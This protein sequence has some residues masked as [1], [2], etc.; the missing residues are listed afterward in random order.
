MSFSDALNGNNP[1]ENGILLNFS[2]KSS[3]D[4]TIVLEPMTGFETVQVGNMYVGCWLHRPQSLF[5]VP[6]RTCSHTN[7]LQI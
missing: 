7:T 3:A 6:K 4:C 1:F 5:I 2:T